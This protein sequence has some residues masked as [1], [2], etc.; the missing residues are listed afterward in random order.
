[1]KV[2]IV[3]DWLTVVGGGERVL[4]QL[5]TVYPEADLFTVVDFLSDEDRQ[6]V[7]GKRAQ[8]TFIQGLPFARKRYRNFLPLM[9]LA[10]EQLD[11]SAYSLVISSSHAVAKGVITGPDQLHVS[12]IHSPI[13]YAWDLQHEY[14]RE[15]GL[16]RGMKSWMARGI[17]S[18]MRM[19]DS[20]TVH[21][22][23]HMVA[24]SAF[25]A[26]RIRKCYGRTAQVIHPPVDISAFA[27]RE[28][29]ESFFL[30]ASRLVP[31]KRIDLIV[32]AFAAM[33]HRRLVV[34]GDGPEFDRIKARAT[35]NVEMTGHLPRPALIDL[36]QRARA[37]VFAAREDF[38]IVAVEAQACGTPVIAFGSGGVCESV[39]GE[40]G[41]GGA[42]TGVFF[43]E[44]SAA[45]IINAVDRFDLSHQMIE[46]SYCRRNAERFSPARFRQEFR[47]CVEGLQSD[48]GQ[49]ASA[50]RSRPTPSLTG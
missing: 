46:P 49:T 45:S 25:I 3:H 40:G 42:P 5:L 6:I 31:Y 44:Q 9:P 30:T 16:T 27:F 14:L 24:N 19:W 47:D 18:Y 7:H 33:P 41:G 43:S 50:T 12:Y 15:S 37:F 23:D 22:I 2:A 34:V 11:M 36:M 48:G 13:R 4:E 10:I 20:R 26:K 35:P 32:D 29:K 39:I 17:L 8:T 28:D 21:G 1:M 38:G